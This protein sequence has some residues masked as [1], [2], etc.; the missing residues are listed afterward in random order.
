MVESVNPDSKTWNLASA[1]ASAT[2]ADPASKPH[3]PRDQSDST[4][5][6]PLDQSNQSGAQ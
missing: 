2:E 1:T 6:A 3:Q 5:R 4:S